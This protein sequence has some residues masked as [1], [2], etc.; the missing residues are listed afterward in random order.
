LYKVSAIILAAGSGNRFGEKKQFKKLNEKPIWV[1]SLNIFSRSECVNDLILVIPNDSLE[2][3]KKSQFFKSL[4]KENNIKLVS[5]GES[6]KDSVVNGL[7]AVNKANNIVC[8]HDAARPFIKTSYIKDS[9]DACSE[10]DGAIIAI[11]VVDTVKKADNKQIKNTID[12]KSLWMAQTPQTFQKEKL[13]YAIKNFSH[14]NITDE[15]MLM[16]E[17]N[18]K[19]KLIEGDQSNFKITNEMD[20]EL[21]KVIVEIE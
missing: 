5:G 10:F 12:R 21:A 16:E 14:L 11:P 8:I 18:F 9:I 6:R 7:K 15:S 3:L 13:L 4:N 1:Y 20:W 2:T 19:I 17:A